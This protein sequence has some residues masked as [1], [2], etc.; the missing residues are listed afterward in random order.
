MSDLPHPQPRQAIQRVPLLLFFSSV[1]SGPARRM[2]SLVASV[3]VNKKRHL[4]VATVD[5]DARTDL[6]ERFG[7]ST[8]PSLVLVDGGR[9]VG[10]L[11]GRATGSEIERLLAECLPESP[12]RRRGSSE[13][14]LT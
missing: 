9:V 11:E 3:R 7:V 12:V 8:V 4:R 14:A 5:T 2:A 6:V 1:R 13:E 10:R